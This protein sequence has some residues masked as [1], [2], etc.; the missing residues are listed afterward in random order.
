MRTIVLHEDDG[1]KS[2][3]IYQSGES[4]YDRLD[5]DFALELIGLQKEEQTFCHFQQLMGNR[6]QKLLMHKVTLV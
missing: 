3:I 5:I 6:I 1:A 4:F 2:F